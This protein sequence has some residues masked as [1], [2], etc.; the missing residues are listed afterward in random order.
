MFALSPAFCSFLVD[1]GIVGI[2][3]MYAACADEHLGVRIDD[4]EYSVKPGKS[5]IWRIVGKDI[6]WRCGSDR[7]FEL[8]KCKSQFEHLVVFRDPTGDTA[9][10]RCEDNLDP[11]QRP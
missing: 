7:P 1:N 5:K 11:K 10:F 3:A 2:H 9:G 6:E 4:T 8:F